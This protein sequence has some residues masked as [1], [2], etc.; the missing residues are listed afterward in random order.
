MSRLVV[1]SSAYFVFWKP[2]TAKSLGTSLPLSLAIFINDTAIESLTP[3]AASIR[4][5]RKER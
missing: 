3:M 1:I 2:A 4:F 5:Y